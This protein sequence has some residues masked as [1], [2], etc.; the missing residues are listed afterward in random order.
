M[1]P[2]L[3]LLAL[4]AAC[5]GGAPPP[6]TAPAAT[7]PPPT[8]SAPAPT[9]VAT[10]SV[11]APAPP[12]KPSEIA[13]SGKTWPFH[14][15]TRAEAVTFNQF[16]M[17]PRVPLVA[18]GPQG[19]SPHVVDKKA[20][21]EASAKKAIQIASGTHGEIEVSKCPFPRHAVVYFDGDVPVA[22]INVCFS[23]GDILLWPSWEAEQP[24]G[25][26]RTEKQREA[27]HALRLKKANLAY[28]AVFPK[29]KTFFRDEVGFAIDEHYE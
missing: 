3:V 15:W 28:P 6:V 18:Y 4:T 10:E 19:W 24:P 14:S 7:A 23:C 16:P 26:E 5:G 27:D 17:R 8:E 21:P 1:R 13:R 11:P 20:I 29:W 12:P 9:P 25:E 2:V 22:S